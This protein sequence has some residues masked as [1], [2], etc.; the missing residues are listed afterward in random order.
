MVTMARTSRSGDSLNLPPP[1]GGRGGGGGGVLA[2][3]LVGLF[4]GVVD[5][6]RV[7]WVRLLF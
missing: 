6:A 5:C 4:G 7:V 3:V 2:L 1:L